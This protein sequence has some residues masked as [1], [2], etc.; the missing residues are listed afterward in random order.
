MSPLPRASRPRSAASPTREPDDAAHPAL[1]VRSLSVA[2]GSRTAVEG[3]SL[4]V[5]PGSVTALLGMNGSGKS[6]VFNA[7]A[8]VLPPRAAQVT[9]QVRIFGATPEQARKRTWLG[10]M[11][12]S[13]D[14]DW[15]F[16]LSVREVVMQGRYAFQ[17]RTRRPR[18]EDHDAVDRAL[19]RV[20][21]VELADR[22]IGQLS[23]GQKKRAF[24]ARAI[25]QGARLLLL[26]E[27]LAGVDR[28]SAEAIT[29]ILREIAAEGSG[30][31]ISVHEISGL[32]RLAD[33]AV[34]LRRQV[35]FTGAAREALAPERL[36]LAFGGSAERRAEEREEEGAPWS[37]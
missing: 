9:G 15:D 2:Y 3:A 6:S 13:E 27:P 18:P 32:D 28:V 20:D 17:G 24:L 29:R 33:H 23:G 16:P 37:C 25:A 30:V 7:V 35:V 14:V 11:P 36:A 5:E 22:Q 21:L 12:Q 19:Q 10:Y 31:L 26:D 8:D 1:E 34:L 4:R